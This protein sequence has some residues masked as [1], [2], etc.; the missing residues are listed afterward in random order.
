MGPAKFHDLSRVSGCSVEFFFSS[1]YSS[2][3]SLVIYTRLFIFIFQTCCRKHPQN[4]EAGSCSVSRLMN[5]LLYSIEDLVGCWCLLW[6]GSGEL[7][8]FRVW[9]EEELG[10]VNFSRV[11]GVWYFP[12]DLFSHSLGAFT[13][14]LWAPSDTL[15]ELWAAC[16][17]YIPQEWDGDGSRKW[18]EDEDG[19]HPK[20][21][22]PPAEQQG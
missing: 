22:C 7:G 20:G 3:W 2:F 12:S 8:S 13:C 6:L 21:C 18:A 11:F 17:E 5:T 16:P 4:M 9:V 14:C 15:G 1:E 10:E 19:S